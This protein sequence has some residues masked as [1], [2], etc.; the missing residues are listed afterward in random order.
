MLFII[1]LGPAFNQLFNTPGNLLCFQFKA[2]ELLSLVFLRLFIA[3]P[4]TATEN[5]IHL[6]S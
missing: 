3:L 5:N 2:L 1:D 4:C 6:H